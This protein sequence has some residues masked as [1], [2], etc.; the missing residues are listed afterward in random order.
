M[1]NLQPAQFPLQLQ[2]L[3]KPSEIRAMPTFSGFADETYYGDEETM[4][5]HK[6]READT[7][8]LTQRIED[9]GVKSPVEIDHGMHRE[10]AITNHHG[11]IV[12]GHGHHR[13]AVQ[14]RREQDGEEV[15]LPVEHE[16]WH[17]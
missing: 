14:E 17:R 3:M 6:L 8:G 11:F 10:R 13:F 1:S 16:D 15:Y 5:G 4:W 7:E 12:F 9:E 2:M